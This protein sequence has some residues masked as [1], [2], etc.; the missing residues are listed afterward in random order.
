M[1]PGTRIQGSEYGGMEVRECKSM[2]VWECE[3]VEVWFYKPDKEM[4]R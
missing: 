2:G 4:T 1:C 3:S